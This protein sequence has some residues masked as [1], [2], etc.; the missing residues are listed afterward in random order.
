LGLRRRLRLRAC[1]TA[2]RRRQGNT[3]PGDQRNAR[4]KTIKPPKANHCIQVTPAV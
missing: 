1:H 3:E 4:I 2:K